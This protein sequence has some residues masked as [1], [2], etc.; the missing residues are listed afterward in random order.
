MNNSITIAS[1]QMHIT[2][3]KTENIKT[4]ESYLKYINKLFPSVSMVVFPELSATNVGSNIKTDAEKIPGTL[5]DL[6]SKW[7]K[8]YN[9]WLIPG[10]IYELSNKK[11]Y[12]STPVFSPTGNLVGVYRK[13][14][15][16]T[17]YEQTEPGS[18]PF[19]F[20]IKDIGTVGIMI[21]YDMW[22]PEV[23]RD[24]TNLGAELIIVPTMTTTGD[25]TQEKIISQAIAITQQCYIV[26]CNGVGLGGVGG[27]QIIDPEGMVLQKNGEGSCIQ[28]SIINFDHVRKIRKLGIAGIT[29]P[30]NDFKNNKQYFKVYKSEL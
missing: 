25:R 26:S 24:L 21:C 7:A 12:N 20:K 29:N 11:I 14:Y 18:S 28:T 30:H 17:P 8:K 15:P 22:F 6:F 19:T 3:N 23:A 4:M 16:W 9:F 5:C 1:I 2:K 10:S 27:S 13:R